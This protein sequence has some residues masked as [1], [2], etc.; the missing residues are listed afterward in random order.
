[1][2][3]KNHWLT[4]NSK[5]LWISRPSLWRCLQRA[6]VLLNLIQIVSNKFR[7]TVILQVLAITVP[8]LEWIPISTK[9]LVRLIKFCILYESTTIISENLEFFTINSIFRSNNSKT[10]NTSGWR[11][12]SFL[13]RKPILGQASTT[14]RK[15]KREDLWIGNCRKTRGSRRTVRKILVLGTTKSKKIKRKTL[16]PCIVTNRQL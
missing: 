13:A 15:W 2:I 1:M 16:N 9:F 14:R 10:S 4:R 11:R 7:A 5:L 12:C 8:S 3:F 6:R